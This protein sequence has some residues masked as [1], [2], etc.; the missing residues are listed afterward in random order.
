MRSSSSGTYFPVFSTL[1]Q[2]KRRASLKDFLQL[3]SNF[4][5]KDFLVGLL[6]DALSAVGFSVVVVSNNFFIDCIASLPI[7][8]TAERSVLITLV[9]HLPSV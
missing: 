9:Y 4:L 5:S 3:I 2:M 7:L 6:L 1:G 8:I